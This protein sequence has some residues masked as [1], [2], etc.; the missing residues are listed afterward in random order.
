[1]NQNQLDTYNKMRL[2]QEV[3]LM[4]QAIDSYNRN[5]PDNYEK[6]IN[7]CEIRIFNACLLYTSPSP[8]DS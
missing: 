3:D 4:Q 5:K 2:D 7:D 1:M 6:L 8:R